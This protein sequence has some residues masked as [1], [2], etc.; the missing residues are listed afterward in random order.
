MTNSPSMFQNKKRFS[1]F[2]EMIVIALKTIISK[3]KTYSH[4]L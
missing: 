3:E 2:R 1:V 4:L